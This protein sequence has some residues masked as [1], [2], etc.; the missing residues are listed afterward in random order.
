MILPLN[1]HPLL[2]SDSFGFE[3]HSFLSLATIG[4]FTAQLC[5][6]QF[7]KGC[8][9]PT[10]EYEVSETMRGSRFSLTRGCSFLRNIRE[11]RNVYGLSFYHI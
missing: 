11:K 10:G 6:N 8:F 2:N 1:C 7:S 9:A 3:F 4:C 5:I